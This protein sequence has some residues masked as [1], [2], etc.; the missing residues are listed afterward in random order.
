MIDY[1][2]LEFRHLKYLQAIAEEGTITAAAAR[3]HI[4]QS[5][6]STQIKQLEELFEVELLH[7]ERDGVTLTPH[8]EIILVHGRDL[9]QGRV[10]VVDMLSA[11]KAGNITDLNL[12]FSSLVDKKTLD[13]IISTTRRIFPYCE[14]HA[15]GGRD[16]RT[17]DASRKWRV[18]RGFSHSSDRAQFGLDDVHYRESSVRSLYEGRRPTRGTRSDPG[19]FAQW[20][21]GNLSVSKSSSR[22]LRPPARTLQICR[23]RT[24]VNDQSRAYP[25]DSDRAAGMRARPRSRKANARIDH[26]AYPRR[27]MDH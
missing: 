12:G 11:L 21:A 27:R 5:A 4:T 14:V 16:R 2:Q 3:V 25:V 17:G 7:R 1:D 24:E 23:Y 13:T 10:D 9:L 20:K 15:D 18:G 8:G 22:G 6:I 19:P 26:S